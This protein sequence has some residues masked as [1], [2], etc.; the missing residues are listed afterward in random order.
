MNLLSKRQKSGKW[1]IKNF[2]DAPT[3]PASGKNFPARWALPKLLA[4]WKR[5]SSFDNTKKP[6]N[7]W[8]LSGVIKLYRNACCLTKNA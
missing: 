6:A 8:N 7:Y 1:A 2:P 5:V 3:K 4:L